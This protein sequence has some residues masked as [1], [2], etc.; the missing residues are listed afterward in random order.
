MD[1]QGGGAG[2]RAL[3]A[4]PLGRGLRA[5][6]R[7]GGV[8]RGRGG[9]GGAARGQVLAAEQPLVHVH[10]GGGLERQGDGELLVEMPAVLARDHHGGGPLRAH[11]GLRFS[12]ADVVGVGGQGGR[13]QG[14]GRKQ[15]EGKL[16]C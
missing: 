9:G 7:G 5:G 3:L 4:H 1:R 16:R 8:G 6:G 15:G 14:Q 2:C 10:A 13:G 11:R 12:G